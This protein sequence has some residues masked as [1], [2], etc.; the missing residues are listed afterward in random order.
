[1]EKTNIYDPFDNR[2]DSFKSLQIVHRTFSIKLKNHLHVTNLI[3]KVLGQ[4][5]EV[6][7]ISN[8]IDQVRAYPLLYGYSSVE[9]Y[10]QF[11]DEIRCHSLATKAP[12]IVLSPSVTFCVFCSGQTELAVNRAKFCKEPLLF[13]LS[14]IGKESCKI[15]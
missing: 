5:Y 2:A 12:T 4:K 11:L 8:F 14:C 6:S 9:N 15:T 13:G 7:V 3:N 1:M 10:T